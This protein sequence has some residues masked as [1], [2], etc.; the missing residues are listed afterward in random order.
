METQIWKG[1]VP[2]SSETGVK[3]GCTVSVGDVISITA[4]DSLTANDS[5]KPH[6][7]VWYNGRH[8]KDWVDA[9]GQ[10]DIQGY[11]Q[12]PTANA[13]A[14]LVR[15]GNQTFIAGKNLP[16]WTVPVSG[17][18]IFLVNDAK[19][20]YSDNKGEFV[21]AVTKPNAVTQG[22]TGGV[23][24]SGGP[25]TSNTGGV[26]DGGGPAT[27]N[28]GPAGSGDTNPRPI[29]GLPANTQLTVTL[30]N[31]E[32]WVRTATLNIDGKVETLEVAGNKAISKAYK[33]TTGKVTISLVDS[34]QGA[35]RLPANLDVSPLGATG[36][37]MTFGAEK[38]KDEKRPGFM[39]VFVHID[40]N[41]DITN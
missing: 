28:N 22:N 36:K 18:L 26:H 1:K 9:D 29:P 10:K 6:N 32:Q 4:D 23:H 37:S 41:T 27:D 31:N 30:I 16:K 12:G 14:L 24:G 17:E 3:T 40:W 33:T 5:S 38:P 34:Q 20:Y 2:A 35:M 21:V 25:I 13:G 15:I 19:G 7:T 8:E 39:D 11:D